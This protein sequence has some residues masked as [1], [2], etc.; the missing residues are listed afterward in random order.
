[1]IIT[2]LLSPGSLETMRAT[3]VE[4]PSMGRLN[5]AF[6]TVIESM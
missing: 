3:F 6:Y 4:P 2:Y 5:M 1:M